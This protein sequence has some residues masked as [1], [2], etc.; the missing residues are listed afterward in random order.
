MWQKVGEETSCIHVPSRIWFSHCFI[1]HFELSIAGR[2]IGYGV[3]WFTFG[4]DSSYFLTQIAFAKWILT[5]PSLFD[6]EEVF[7]LRGCLRSL[8]EDELQLLP[9]GGRTVWEGTGLVYLFAQSDHWMEDIIDPP[10]CWHRFLSLPLLWDFFKFRILHIPVSRKLRR[11]NLYHENGAG[12]RHVPSISKDYVGTCMASYELG[13]LERFDD[14][15]NV[16]VQ[17]NWWSIRTMMVAREGSRCW[18]WYPFFCFELANHP[19]L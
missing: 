4:T 3:L 9:Y 12:F 14:P 2:R 10:I 5:L 1:I 11:A 18:C 7:S 16:H 19:C 15:R 17:K 13:I 6:H 8:I